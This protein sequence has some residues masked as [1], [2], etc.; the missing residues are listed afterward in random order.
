[1]FFVRN[2]MPLRSGLLTPPF[3]VPETKG[4][5]LEEMDEVFGSIGL[6]AADQERQAAINRRIG[7][8]QYDDESEKSPSEV[9]EA[10]ADFKA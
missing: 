9:H 3:Q 1:M 4:L 2:M 10:H 8:S 6:A 7:L 5:T